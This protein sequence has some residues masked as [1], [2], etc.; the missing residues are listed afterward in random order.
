MS[1]LNFFPSLSLSLVRKNVRPF[2]ETAA[3]CAC[4]HVGKM[5]H[6][7]R[8][9]LEAL[10]AFEPMVSTHKCSFYVFKWSEVGLLALECNV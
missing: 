6:F 1:T 3:E 4:L 2:G 9:A 10:A 5:K 8:Q 7:P